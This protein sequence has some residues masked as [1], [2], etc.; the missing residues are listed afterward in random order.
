MHAALTINNIIKI[1]CGVKWRSLG[2]ILSIPHETLDEIASKYPTK[3]HRK[4]AIVR[5]WPSIDPLISWRRIIH[6]LDSWGEHG[7]ANKMRHYA[8][9]LTGII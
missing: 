3:D 2:E 1:L 8:E 6:N 9:E 4:M 5:H 7:E